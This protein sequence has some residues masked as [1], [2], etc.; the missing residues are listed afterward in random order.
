MSVL[1]LYTDSAIRI[2]QKPVI[3]NYPSRIRF[4]QTRYRFK[5]QTLSAAG[6]AQDTDSVAAAFKRYIKQEIIIFLFNINT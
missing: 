3:K 4:Y 1:R 2:E 5:R 6:S